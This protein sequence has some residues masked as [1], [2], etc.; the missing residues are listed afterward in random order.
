MSVTVSVTVC[1]TLTINFIQILY[2]TDISFIGF[3]KNYTIPRNIRKTLYCF[4][5]FLIVDVDASTCI[6]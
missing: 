3:T 4:C 1:D 2:V 6:E 5:L